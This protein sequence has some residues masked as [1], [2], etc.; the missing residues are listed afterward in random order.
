MVI[1]KLSEIIYHFCNEGITKSNPDPEWI[2]D[3]IN[4]IGMFV[5]EHYD[6]DVKKLYDDYNLTAFRN[7]NQGLSFENFVTFVEANYELFQ[8]YHIN[9]SEQRVL[10]NFITKII[11]IYAIQNFA[12]F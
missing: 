3:V 4:K 12:Q 11:L 1:Y 6:G 7:K 10:F 2:N 8:S 9:S 5:D